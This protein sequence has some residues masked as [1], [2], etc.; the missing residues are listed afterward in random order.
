MS[1]DRKTVLGVPGVGSREEGAEEA[2]NDN[3]GNV[4]DSVREHLAAQRRKLD[5][6]TRP[7]AAIGELDWD[8]DDDVDAA[9][10]EA[11]AAPLATSPTAGGSSSEDTASGST[12]SAD[13]EPSAAAP[14][15]DE[16]PAREEAAPEPAVTRGG[17]MMMSTA[18][19]DL[20]Q[21]AADAIAAARGAAESAAADAG[22]AS[23]EAIATGG[24]SAR[25]AGGGTML[26]STTDMHDK[27]G[28]DL[29]SADAEETAAA[30][31][32]TAGHP[33]VGSGGE[34]Q[35]VGAA[36]PS[37]SATFA[38]DP[39]AVSQTAATVQQ[40]ISQQ[41]SG[42]DVESYDDD[43]PPARF[44]GPKLIA[45]IIVLA[46]VSFAAWYVITQLL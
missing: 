15:E 3:A 14:D 11:I 39:G 44:F 46:G 8:L 7:M 32:E 25:T 37:Q 1:D 12:G 33:S 5:L 20:D 41:Y 19:V 24:S 27:I 29:V 22:D 18:G 23:A 35:S 28:A 31:G 17:T 9:F 30:L 6:R 16:E 13:A 2:S 38:T 36:A 26:F 42:S 4:S 34:S 43:L 21:V 45:A 10:E 40:P